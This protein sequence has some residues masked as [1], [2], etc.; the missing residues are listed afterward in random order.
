MNVD[1]IVN[2]LLLMIGIV[3]IEKFFYYFLRYY[4]CLIVFFLGCLEFEIRMS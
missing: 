3:S 4:N 2:C 1:D